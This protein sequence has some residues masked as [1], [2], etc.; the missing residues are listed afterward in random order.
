MVN[1][2]IYTAPG[3]G[4]CVAAKKAMTKYGIPFT[5]VDTADD[6][7]AAAYVR[8]DL[9]YTSAP[10]TALTY[11]DGRVRSWGG[12]DLEQV[13]HTR[14]VLDR[15]GHGLGAPDPTPAQLGTLAAQQVHV[16]GA[17]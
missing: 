15:E 1:I 12:F 4:A 7:A 17:A 9:G 13:K 10:V 11:K 6:P 8:D 16:A 14:Q 2:T 5:E 3:C